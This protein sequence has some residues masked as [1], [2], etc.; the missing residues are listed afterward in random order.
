MRLGLC[1]A[2]DI[3]NLWLSDPRT[4]EAMQSLETH[5]V[6]TRKYWSKW[7]QIWAH[8]VQRSSLRRARGHFAGNPV[9]LEN[10]EKPRRPSPATT[11]VTSHCLLSYRGIGSGTVAG[12]RGLGGAVSGALLAGSSPG[13]ICGH[14][15]VTWC[16]RR[17]ACSVPYGR[18]QVDWP[19]RQSF[20]MESVLEA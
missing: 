3:A 9:S 12:Q 19:T 14:E 20:W 16:S 5:E 8:I 18:I 11:P 7:P 17:R 15:L 1:R 10:S 4:S 13:G 2:F 6:E